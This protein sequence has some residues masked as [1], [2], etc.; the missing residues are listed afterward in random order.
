MIR[1]VIIV[2][3]LAAAAAAAQDHSPLPD[4]G[5]RGIVLGA[6]MDVGYLFSFTQPE[7]NE[8]RYK[9][10]TPR[11]NAIAV[12]NATV[13]LFKPTSDSSRF[14][15]MVGLQIG[16]DVEN[17]IPE[18]GGLAAKNWLG[19]LYYSGIAY[20]FPI[21][22]GLEVMAGILPG[23][24]GYPHFQSI[25]NINYT[26]PYAVDY[27]PYFHLGAQVSYPFS[28]DV[29]VTLM[30]ANGYDY[31]SAGNGAVSAAARG[32][33]RVADNLT[34]TQS[35][36]YGPDQQNTAL[37][38]W[39]FLSNT[40]AEW[41]P[42]RWTLAASIHA[43]SETVEQDVID[44]P[45]TNAM[46]LHATWYAMVVWVRYAITDEWRIAARPE[47]YHDPNGVRTGSE[48]TIQAYTIT[49]EYRREVLPGLLLSAKLEGRYDHTTGEGFY[50]DDFDVTN[51]GQL[52]FGGGLAM[53]YLIGL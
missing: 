33:W 39:R 11:L 34:L 30:I 47:I 27:V 25:N 46:D 22:N 42:G 28:K 24:S 36:Y 17:Q 14:G 19:Q 18:D 41:T 20:R 49:T 6:Y 35:F 48:Q 1:S 32:G 50:T 15:F 7:P 37:P 8:W 52:L 29:D 9:G 31:L 51:A 38:Y 5:Q 16:D 44:V 53:R 40:I 23:V 10:T 43:G 13:A 4:T 2:V 26:R 12:N 21:G 3:V 45:W